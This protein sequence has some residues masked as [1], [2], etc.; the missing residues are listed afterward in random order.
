MARNAVT[1][2]V[3]VILSLSLLSSARLDS[4]FSAAAAA[5]IPKDE[6]AI[7]TPSWDPLSAEEK[8]KSGGGGSSSSIKL[9]A[10]DL[11]HHPIYL[12]ADQ[13]A[14]SFRLPSG[15]RRHVALPLRPSLEIS[16]GNDMVTEERVEEGKMVE[17][18]LKMEPERGL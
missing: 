15:G 16:Y 7:S 2:F 5:A 6:I 11:L 3:T 14:H 4:S 10:V 17:K 8:E 18:K 9:D 12:T 1:V 13:I